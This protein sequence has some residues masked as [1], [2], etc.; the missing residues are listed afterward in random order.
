MS[1][2]T[3]A[4]REGTI[5]NSGPKLGSFSRPRRQLGPPFSCTIARYAFPL[6]EAPRPRGRQWRLRRTRAERVHHVSRPRN[7]KRARLSRGYHRFAADLTS[8][9]GVLGRMSDEDAPRVG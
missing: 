7:V 2:R 3:S 5:E 4:V 1:I 8:S 6:D 9:G